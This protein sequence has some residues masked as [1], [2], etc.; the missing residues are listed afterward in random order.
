MRPS[1]P[2]VSCLLLWLTGCG[3]TLDLD[4][5][6]PDAAAP[7]DAGARM[8]AALV[9][10]AIPDAGARDAGAPDA[11][12]SIDASRP[13]AGP[14]IFVTCTEETTWREERFVAAGMMDVAS[15]GSAIA[16]AYHQAADRVMVQLLDGSLAPTAQYP[17]DGAT[18]PIRLTTSASGFALSFAYGGDV[19]IA[20]PLG[21]FSLTSSGDASAAGLA[22]HD[23]TYGW[24]SGLFFGPGF[25][26]P[27]LL[28]FDEPSS[29]SSFRSVTALG[30]GAVVTDARLEHDAR[31]HA[32]AVAWTDTSGVHVAAVDDTTLSMVGAHADVMPSA[33]SLLPTRP[34]L[35]LALSPTL[36]AVGFRDARALST[37]A[38]VAIVDAAGTTR[39]LDL[40]AEPGST[41]AVASDR[42]AP[43]LGVARIVGDELR[44]EAHAWSDLASFGSVT[45]AAPT[46]GDLL[47]LEAE[48]GSMTWLV[49]R[50][51]R[52][53]TGALTVTRIRCYVSG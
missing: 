37:T 12:I 21:G 35:S 43:L 51:H 17:W 27:L 28:E 29:R 36:V 47:A 52:A 8:D 20:D 18:D 22:S 26:S 6:P 50:K 5:P 9:D 30:D 15:R 38:R 40:G 41:V 31:T 11:T 1:G 34:D 48:A 25:E 23:P 42:G 4:P 39:F 24:I 33:A 49:A 3:L 10:A 46:E 13:D 16:V 14:P 44:F 19:S 45:V 53:G 7:A 2:A 32:F